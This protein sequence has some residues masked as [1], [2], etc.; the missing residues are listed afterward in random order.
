VLCTHV[1]LVSSNC[2]SRPSW[3][4]LH[5][6]PP[7]GGGGRGLVYWSQRSLQG[8]EGEGPVTASPGQGGWIWGRNSTFAAF[9][10]GGA[11]DFW[12]SAACPSRPLLWEHLNSLPSTCRSCADDNPCRR[13]PWASGSDCCRHHT[14][15]TTAARRHGHTSTLGAS[16]G[17]NLYAA[18]KSG[19]NH[20]TVV[21][22]RCPVSLYA[23]AH[24]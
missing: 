12:L 1:M 7:A 10:G 21:V 22:H 2:Q 24:F 13:G 23:T 3:G 4:L 6:L 20:L 14:Q 11:L 5:E 8:G 16:G 17:S 18:S 9:G 19:F 15:T